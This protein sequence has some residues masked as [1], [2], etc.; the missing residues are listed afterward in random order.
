MRLVHAVGIG[1]V[2]LFAGG[3]AVADP[4][5]YPG[6][7]CTK[8]SFS[9][10][11]LEVTT[12]GSIKNTHA[13][14]DLGVL[15]PIT[16]PDQTTSIA[17]LTMRVHDQDDGDEVTCLLRCRDDFTTAYFEEE[18]GSGVANL[19]NYHLLTFSGISDYGNG[20][21]FVYCSLPDVDV[22]TSYIISYVADF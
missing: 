22:G 13:S 20:A 18:Q 5:V 10:G 14:Q 16:R 3:V 6:L 2:L 7:E 4:N 11:T 9:S 19:E 21:C 12:D 8:A 1:A 15:C 17:A